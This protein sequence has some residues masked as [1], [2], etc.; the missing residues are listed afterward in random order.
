MNYMDY[1]NKH[2][3]NIIPQ[4]A[5]EEL[6]KETFN[7]IAFNLTKS[8]GPLGSS[9]TIFDGSIVEATKDGYS[10][11]N[12]YKLTNTYKKMIYNLIKRP[13][14]KMNNTVGDGTTTAIALTNHILNAY[15][16]S[17]KNSL[18]KLYRMPRELT[19]AWDEVIQTICDKV[20]S[21]A[22]PIDPEDY[23][24]IYNIAYVTSNGNEEVSKAVAETYK[25]AKSPAIKMKDSPTN[26]SYI[27]SIDGFEF[28]TNAIDNCYVKNE[29]LS[30]T[31][32]DISV[33][34]FDHTVTTDIFNNVIIKINEVLRAMGRK[35]VIVAPKYDEYM[36]ESV[37]RQY[38]NME[39]NQY[40]AINLI[41][42]Q[43]RTGIL[44]P[45][46]TEDL[47]VILHTKIITEDIVN[48]ITQRFTE[49]SPDAV[50]EDMIENNTYDL[51]RCIGYA[52]SA[53]ITCKN[54]TIFKP[55][56]IE[57][58]EFYQNALTNAQSELDD[59]IAN[60]SAEQQ[61]YTSKIYDA[62]SRLLQ[63]QMK[64][65]IYYVG[66]DSDLQKQIL[67]DSIDDVIKCLR[68]AIKYGVVPGCQVAILQSCKEI[69]E[70]FGSMDK[71]NVTNE[72]GMKL[73]ITHMIMSATTNTYKQVL[74][75]PKGNGLNPII[76]RPT[77]TFTE[78][79]Q[80]ELE[81]MKED[82]RN[83][84]IHSIEKKL[85]AE[86][87]QKYSDKI[88]EI[89]DNSVENSM[90]YDIANL[91]FND[92]IITSA[93]TDTMVLTAA[94]ELVKI[95]ISGNQCVFLDYDKSEEEVTNEYHP[96]G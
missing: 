62:R 12:K 82:D 50:I 90:A 2:N 58:D 88:N 14:T 61:S 71:K 16:N 89:I 57:D 44:T 66:A 93:Q 72:I 1:F 23:D 45:H 32:T 5:Y 69:I 91:E 3:I 7:D 35:L 96:Y 46:Q 60:T 56:D 10:I 9:A 19:K 41:L 33:M 26:K 86:Y 8:L 70:E 25:E 30:T 36:C 67:Q 11:L 49:Q 27:K 53:L 40:R 18:N 31:E 80:T 21:K 28:P 20:N 74:V 77:Y 13:C 43:Y 78:E 76:E 17:S 73:I 81:N 48:T 6:V 84:R 64:N 52:R 92:K 15:E 65:Y 94:S 95:L 47:A 87:Q 79:E 63:L 51:F 59:I 39:F 29:D 24:T 37:L 68:S 34:I 85:N 75:G 55:Q 54:G 4:E 42:T 83:E 38:V 22:K